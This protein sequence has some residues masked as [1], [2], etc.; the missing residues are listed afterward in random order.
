M[1][2]ISHVKS[3]TIADGTNNSIVL[4][5]DWNSA[6]VYTLQDAVSILAGGNTAGALANISSGTFYL[7]GGNNITLS[8]NAN[9]VT[10]AG[11]G[12]AM[13]SQW[14]DELPS[15]TAVSTYYSGSTSA[16]ANTSGYTFSIYFVPMILPS[17]VVFS[18][19]KLLIS[20]QT[21]AGTGSNTHVYSAGFYTN[22]A[23]TL[24]LVTGY[25]GGLFV[26]QN[27][28]TAATYSGWTC[29]TGSN[30]TG[31]GAFAGLQAVSYTSSG[32]NV[33]SFI[34]NAAKLL[35]LDNG[36]AFTTLSD[37][38]YWFALAMCTASSG[39]NVYSNVGVLQSNA[40]S[41]VCLLEFGAN[42]AST[43]ASLYAWGAISTTFTSANT[44]ATFFPLPSAV[45]VA[46]MTTTNS[47]GLRFHFPFLRGV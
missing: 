30:T 31:Q 46:N 24:S 29:S 36:G 27:S 18:V 1:G 23:S 25:Y 44:A 21:I 16:G 33:S 8:Q 13:V 42:T 4:P 20:N 15:T 47:S 45:P 7:A 40:I 37:G 3:I 26:S 17:P 38:N 34:G 2:T 6:H 5:S 9:S 19:V 22:N 10:I 28:V 35:R 14:P 11:I 43:N 41:S 32:G 39:G 12:G